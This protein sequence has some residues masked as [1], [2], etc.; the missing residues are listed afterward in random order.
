MTAHYAVAHWQS[1][2]I[3]AEIGVFTL[4]EQPRDWIIKQP[5]RR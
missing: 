5:S 4:L 2:L 3:A 1:L